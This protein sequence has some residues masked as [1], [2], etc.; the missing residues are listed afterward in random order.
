[1]TG[2]RAFGPGAVDADDRSLKGYQLGPTSISE[3][4]AQSD[5]R[6]FGPG[7]QLPGKNLV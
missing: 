3:M 2:V 6:T 7:S 1:M 4:L 5:F